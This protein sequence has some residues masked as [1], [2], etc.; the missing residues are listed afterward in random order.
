MTTH[1]L[2]RIIAG[3]LMS[4]SLAV[5][6]MGVSVGT[7]Q[8]QTPPG[9][10]YTWCPGDPPVETGNKR[11]NPVRWDENICHTYWFVYHG[12]AAPMRLVRFEVDELRDDKGTDLSQGLPWEVRSCHLRPPL[13]PE[14]VRGSIFSWASSGGPAVGARF[15]SRVKG[16]LIVEVKVDKV[17][18]ERHKLTIP[19]DL[20]D[21]PIN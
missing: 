21:V 7:A 4:A 14:I 13:P 20:K 12:R 3:A 6:G 8:A 9:G 16:R 18:G 15:L 2:K 5:T 10:P 19:M 17:S 1:N 11:V